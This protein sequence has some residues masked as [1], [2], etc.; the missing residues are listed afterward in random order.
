MQSY[1]TVFDKDRYIVI[2]SAKAK[3]SDAKGYSGAVESKKMII[4][5]IE[6]PAPV[7]VEPEPVTRRCRNCAA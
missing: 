4:S 5:V 7:V 2:P 3:F 6:E 1:N